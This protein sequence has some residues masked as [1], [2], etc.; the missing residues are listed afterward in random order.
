MCLLVPNVEAVEAVGGGKPDMAL[1][2]FLGSFE[3][4]D[5]AWMDPSLLAET[6]PP[7]SDTSLGK[8]DEAR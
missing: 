4:V 2:E 3:T 5:G 8:S 6:E 7:K 1:L